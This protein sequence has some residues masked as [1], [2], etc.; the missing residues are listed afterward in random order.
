MARVLGLDLGATNTKA[1]LVEQLGSEFEVTSLAS[2]P[3][4]GDRGHEAAIEG[5][6]TQANSMIEE[7]GGVDAVGVGTPGLFEADTGVVTIFTN[8][9]GQW[10]GVPLLDLLKAGFSLPVSLINDARA[11]TLAE[12]TLGAGR[13]AKVVVAMTLGTGIGGG[14]M[15]NGQLHMGATGIAGEISHQTVNPGGRPCGCG[16]VGCAEAEARSDVLVSMAGKETV[17]AVYAGAATGDE[18]CIEA[19]EHASNAVGI[20]IANAITLLGP[21]RVVIGGGIVAGGAQVIDPIR[22]ATWRYVHLVDPTEVEI[23]PAALGSEAGA[24]GAGLF[25]LAALG[26]S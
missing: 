21:D 12:G 10:R 14:I 26:T 25:A 9:P 22:E 20:A 11:F 16:N 7:V 18:R 8:L 4:G 1:V 13:G 23:V 15:I 17:E 19:V 6:L 5:V 2:F 24:I 3:T